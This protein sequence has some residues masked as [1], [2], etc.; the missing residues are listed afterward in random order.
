MGQDVAGAGLSP[1]R[2]MGHHGLRLLLGH[3]QLLLCPQLLLLHSGLMDQE[4][5]LLAGKVRMLCCLQMRKLLLALLH[6]C[7]QP[8]LQL[9]Q[10]AVLRR[11][12]LVTQ[13]HRRLHPRLLLGKLVALGCLELLSLLH[14]N[15]H[16]LLT[17]QER[18]AQAGHAL[19]EPCW[20]R[21][22]RLHSS[23]ALTPDCVRRLARTV[24][25]LLPHIGLRGIPGEAVGYQ[26]QLML[27]TCRSLREGG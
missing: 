10:L 15:P 24:V 23:D 16:R 7:L 8:G 1:R 6:A 19:Q 4:A 5:H 14:N 13:L 17:T 25:H 18:A 12:L 3:V 27:L 9:R 22:L 20:W 26:L 21:M 2:H 11:L